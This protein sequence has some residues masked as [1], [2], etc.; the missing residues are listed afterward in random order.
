VS[1]FTQYLRMYDLDPM[2]LTLN[3]DLYKPILNMHI[4]DR[5]KSW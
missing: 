2:T 3:S 1:V 4:D 5:R